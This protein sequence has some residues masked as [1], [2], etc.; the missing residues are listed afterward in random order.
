MSEKIEKLNHDRPQFDADTIERLKQYYNVNESEILRFAN[1][2][3]K[4][5]RFD[6][7]NVRKTGE[8]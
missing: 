3:S 8:Q 4:I 7:L 5:G 2:N 6:R 1:K